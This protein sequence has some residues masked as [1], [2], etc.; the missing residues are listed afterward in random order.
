MLFVI[1]A[2]G[3]VVFDVTV[4]LSVSVQLLPSVTVTVYVLALLI[5]AAALL[6]KLLSQLYELPPLAVTLIDVVAHV[7]S[8]EPVLFVITAVGLLFTVTTISS[9]S[10]HPFASVAVTVYVVVLV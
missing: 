4:I 2:V 6:P 5:V 10:V 7:S 3:A 8:V 9:V 1:P